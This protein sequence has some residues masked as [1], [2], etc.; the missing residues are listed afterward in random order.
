MALEN[1]PAL[2]HD[3]SESKILC[4]SSSQLA[5]GSLMTSRHH[6][7]IK[8]AHQELSRKARSSSSG[9]KGASFPRNASNS[10]SDFVRDMAATCTTRTR[11]STQRNQ[12]VAVE[13]TLGGAWPATDRLEPQTWS[14]SCQAA[15]LA[16]CEK[17]DVHC[18]GG[19]IQSTSEHQHVPRCATFNSGST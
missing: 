9:V 16:S 12:N 10:A 15:P 13:A 3:D 4:T 1:L 19:E 18:T 14:G 7:R 11:Q 8:S 6:S 2:Q 17:T 5:L